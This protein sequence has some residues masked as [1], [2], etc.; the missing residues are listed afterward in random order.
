MLGVCFS[1]STPQIEIATRTADSTRDFS[2][3]PEL[4]LKFQEVN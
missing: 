4:L 3:T 1:Y 2:N